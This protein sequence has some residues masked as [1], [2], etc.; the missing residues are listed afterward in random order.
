LQDVVPG[1]DQVSIVI[2]IEELV[3]IAIRLL[4]QQSLH[5]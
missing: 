5:P 4:A 3:A 1:R 2:E